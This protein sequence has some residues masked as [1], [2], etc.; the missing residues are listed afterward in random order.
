[1]TDSITGSDVD[2]VTVAWD[3]DRAKTKGDL[4]EFLYKQKAPRKFKDFIYDKLKNKVPERSEVNFIDE[5]LKKSSK[6]FKM[7]DTD[8]ITKSMWK[9]QEAIFLRDV[10]G[11]FKTWGRIKPFKLPI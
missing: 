8:K 7:L 3:L 9:G 5:L 2:R 4:R 6:G 1:M 10:K 11:R